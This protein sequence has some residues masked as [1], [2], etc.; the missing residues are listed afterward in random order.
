MDSLTDLA[1]LRRQE[2]QWRQHRRE[3]II[4]SIKNGMST[5][6]G[7]VSDQLQKLAK[8]LGAVGFDMD[9]WWAIT[10][11]R[12][13]CSGCGRSK[14]HIARPNRKGQLMCRLV[15]HHD[16][17][18]DLLEDLFAEISACL[19]QVL[20]DEK[21]EQFAKRSASVISVHEP[22][23]VCN[24]CNNA[25]AEAKRE[26]KLPRYFSF[27]PAE[28]RQFCTAVPNQPHQIDVARARSLW[29]GARSTYELREKLA[30]Q[31][32]TIAANN[33][34]WYQPGAQESNPDIIHAH[35]R[36]ISSEAGI[37]ELA[38]ELCGE[39]APAPMRDQSA[40]RTTPRSTVRNPPTAGQIEHLA[41]VTHTSEWNS[42]PVDWKC[43]ACRRGKIQIIR[44][45][46]KAK[47]GF[48]ARSVYYLDP[49]CGAASKKATLCGD[50][51]QTA[52]DLGREAVQ[53]AGTDHTEYTVLV[54]VEE[55]AR[56]VVP[57]P[58]SRHIY[59]NEEADVVVDEI[60]ERILASYSQDTDDYF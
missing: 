48:N 25:D 32:A 50:C 18:G 26:L 43:P 3:E 20:A 12:W 13:T 24:D 39:K 34:H 2:Q 21:A 51:E 40:W 31:I 15:A 1:T 28:I 42:L 9:E 45:T 57:R 38:R 49:E 36:Q 23:V 56:I 17:M 35:Y 52:V 6:D 53:A 33:Q 10:P 46:N 41:R 37:Y 16:H 29:E 47:L 22:A 8:R 60:K 54:L 7:V 19:P 5:L 59:K 11:P 30:R 44:P 4:Q 27:S 58:H 14:L 55:I